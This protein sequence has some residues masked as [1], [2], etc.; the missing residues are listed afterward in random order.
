MSEASEEEN[1]EVVTGFFG[2]REVELCG[3]VRIEG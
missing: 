3:G 2:M 1:G